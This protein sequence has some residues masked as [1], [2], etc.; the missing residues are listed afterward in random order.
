MIVQLN[1]LSQNFLKDTYMATQTEKDFLN[2]T[3]KCSI[4][5][6]GVDEP[7]YN[8]F[9]VEVCEG[10]YFDILNHMGYRNMDDLLKCDKKQLMLF[11]NKLAELKK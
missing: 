10:C 7:L 4:C 11:L 5:N 2:K 1:P 6:D 8:L 9:G 3:G